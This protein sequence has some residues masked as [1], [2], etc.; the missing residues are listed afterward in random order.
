MSNYIKNKDWSNAFLLALTLDH[1]MRLYNV[2][3]S[4]IE[5]NEDKDSIIGS[6]SLENTISLLDDG[7]LVKLFKKIR[8]W[9]VNFKFFEISQ[10]L[11]NVVLNNF[12]VDKLTEVS[13]LM[14]IMESIIPYN[15]RHYNRIE[16]MVEQTYVL[17]YTVEQMNKLIA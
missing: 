17:D 9:N 11:L 2:I 13:G 5:T 16:E 4:S 14:K 15:E 8:D 10:K 12:A 1:S 7:Q 6:F 3:K